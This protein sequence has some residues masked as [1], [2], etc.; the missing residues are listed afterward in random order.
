MANKE[1]PLASAKSPPKI[2]RDEP[3]GLYYERLIKAEL[4]AKERRGVEQL[5]IYDFLPAAT[6]T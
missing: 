5:I 1:E 3:L 2:R 4:L 6:L